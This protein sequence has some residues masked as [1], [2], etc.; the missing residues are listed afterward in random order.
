MEVGIVGMSTITYGELIYGAYKSHFS[1]KSQSILEDLISLIP[2]LSMHEQASKHYGEIRNKL[3]KQGR[4]IGNNDLWIAAH[5]LSID[6]TLITNNMK[7]FRRIPH[8]KIENW[9]NSP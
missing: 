7:E 8:L 1:K 2:A 9:V 6:A 3:E 4:V 5:A